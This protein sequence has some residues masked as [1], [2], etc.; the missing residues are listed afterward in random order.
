M[1]NIVIFKSYSDLD[2]ER[3]VHDFNNFCRNKLTVFGADLKWDSPVWKGIVGFRKL[4]TGRGGLKM[5]TC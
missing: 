4:D 3:N 5:N 2:A 1:N